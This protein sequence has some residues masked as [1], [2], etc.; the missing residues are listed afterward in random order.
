[1]ELATDKAFTGE[2]SFLPILYCYTADVSSLQEREIGTVEIG[3]ATPTRFSISASPLSSIDRIL[4]RSIDYTE[5]ELTND[6]ELTYVK[7]SPTHYIVNI[8]SNEPIILI[9]ANIY[10]SRW[11]A[12]VD[13]QMIE[14]IP[15][16]YHMNGFV[17][18]R[19]GS[20]KLDIIFSGEEWVNIGWVLS[21]ITIVTM[22]LYG[23]RQR[24]VEKLRQIRQ[25]LR[26]AGVR[27]SFLKG[28]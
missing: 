15:V 26:K 10:D 13:G 27:L 22:F 12:E 23:L 17:I 1:V 5:P 6:F 21:T 28:Q 14:S 4:V 8:N 20:F 9:F 2:I 16:L 11:R 24:L 19:T 18:D 3:S 7:T 25:R